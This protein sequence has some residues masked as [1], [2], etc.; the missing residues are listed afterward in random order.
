[1]TSKGL[2]KILSRRQA[3]E[4]QSLEAY[5]D[6]LRLEQKAR[7][8][9]WAVQE[10]RTCALERCSV[11]EKGWLQTKARK[12]HPR[13]HFIFITMGQPVATAHTLHVHTALR[14]KTRWDYQTL[15]TSKHA[16]CRGSSA[17]MSPSGIPSTAPTDRNRCDRNGPPTPHPPLCVRVC[18]GEW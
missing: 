16:A 1:M 4:T 14:V 3:Q 15:S 9:E 12:G 11:K 6:K 5:D 18:V 17:P 2:W 7:G 8:R 10:F 13:S